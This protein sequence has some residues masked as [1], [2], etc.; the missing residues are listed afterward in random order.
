MSLMNGSELHSDLTRRIDGFYVSHCHKIIR[1]IQSKCANRPNLTSL[2]EEN[3][4]GTSSGLF[5]NVGSACLVLVNWRLHPG[6]SSSMMWYAYLQT[7][8]QHVLSDLMAK[9]N[10]RSLVVRSMFL[11]MYLDLQHFMDRL[12]SMNTSQAIG[13]RSSNLSFASLYS[14][15]DNIWTCDCTWSIIASWVY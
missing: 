11:Q 13:L 2:Y 1:H 8:I 3:R 10:G 4:S 6:Q 7:L 14:T 12:C 9:G 15:S 5:I